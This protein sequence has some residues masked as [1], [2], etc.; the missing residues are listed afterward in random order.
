MKT[1]LY[2][3]LALTLNTS[4]AQDNNSSKLIGTWEFS[5]DNNDGGTIILIFQSETQLLF[6]NEPAS[7]TATNTEIQVYAEGQYITYPYTL[8]NNV[9]SITF[10]DGTVIPFKK[11]NNNNT[12][13]S[14]QT[15]SQGKEYLLKGTLCSYSSSSDGGYSSTTMVYFDGQGT[16]QYKSESSYSGSEGSY[17]SGDDG[18]EKGR[19]V[20]E[21]NR[22]VL[23]FADGTVGYAEI[24][25]RQDDGSISEIKYDGTI[26]AKNLCD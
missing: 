2:I 4:F 15:A 3:I 7:Y 9:L 23:Y 21:N 16:F 14:K 6:D 24:F 19:Y 5:I 10:P 12:K 17:Y 22:I 1:L 26:Y 25:F 13:T 11:V 18:V 20:V 8:Q